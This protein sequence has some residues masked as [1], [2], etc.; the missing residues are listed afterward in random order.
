MHKYT[1]LLFAILGSLFCLPNFSAGQTL[2][3]SLPDAKGTG[4]TL[5]SGENSFTAVCFLGTECPM[6]RVYAGRLNAMHAD[7][8]SKGGQII[9]VM[10]NRQDSLEDIQ[11]YQSNFELSFPVLVDKGNQVANQFGATRTP[12]VF[13]LDSELKLRYRGRIDDQYAPGVAK[14]KA[15]REDLRIAIDEVL[16]GKPVSIKETIARGC[17]IGKVKSEQNTE[18]TGDLTFY[19]D[20]LPVLQKHC[21]ECHRQGEI[22]PFAMNQYDEVVGWA[23]TMLETIEDG[24]MPPWHADPAHGSFLNE[25]HMPQEDVDIFRNWVSTGAAEGSVNERPPMREYVTGWSLTKEPD[26]VLPMRKRP[27]VIPKDGVVEYQY[28]VVDPG[29]EKDTWV[30][31]AEVIPGNRSVVHHAIV[32]V[33]PPD[34]ARFQGIGWLTAYVPGQKTGILPPGRARLIPAGSR[35]VFQMHY[36]PNGTEQED[37]TKVGLIF[38]DEAEEITHSVYTLF[39]LNQEFEIPPNATNHEVQASLSLRRLPRGGELLAIT[40]HMHFRGKSFSLHGIHR[41]EDGEA[42]TLLSVPNYDFN[43][44]H[45][46]YLRDPIPLDDLADISFTASFDNSGAN[47]FNPDPN[48]TVFWGDQTWEE[49]AV[50]FFDVSEPRK[51]V[52]G[53]RQKSTSSEGQISESRSQE[54]ESYISRVLKQMDKDGDGVVKR[55]EPDIIVNRWNFRQWDRNRDDKITKEEIRAAAERIYR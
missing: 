30:K 50:A 42:R 12:E 6:A 34:G 54:I 20:V 2:S 31:A 40:P 1:R 15:A 10:S 32:F 46:Y 44:Q 19:K 35:L 25:R 48:E 11:S 13:L 39:A 29:F 38:A 23:D 36:T 37:T 33:R 3:F 53:P 16:A 49:M 55:G 43:W 51:K 21:I 4:F 28:F 8:A 9:A 47:P 41:P 14:S 45:S 26:L 17:L 7:Y 27:F 52:A 24:R 5:Q 18:R 22:G